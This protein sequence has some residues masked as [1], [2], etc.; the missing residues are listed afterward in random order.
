M[1]LFCIFAILLVACSTEQRR[2]PARVS[3]VADVAHV[4]GTNLSPWAACRFPQLAN[5]AAIRQAQP[6]PSEALASHVYTA[7]DVGG[8]WLIRTSDGSQVTRGLFFTAP[9]RL[10]YTRSSRI[11]AF[12]RGFDMVPTAVIP[13]SAAMDTSLLASFWEFSPP[14]SLALVRTTGFGGPVLSFRV[15]GDSLVGI[16]QYTQDVIR[17]SVDTATD[18]VTHLAGRRVRCTR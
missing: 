1:R 11:R 13:D 4:A 2:S 7:D 6:C 16:L 17:M 9:V 10:A 18:S 15:R 12:G 3:G 8:C 5:P 14:D